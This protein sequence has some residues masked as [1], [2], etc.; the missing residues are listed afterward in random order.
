[1]SKLASLMIAASLALTASAAASAA[2]GDITLRVER[3]GIMTS[4]GGEFASAQSGKMLVEGE[5]LMV[6]E[7]SAA[8]VFY[9]NNCTR[10]YNAP[11]VY[12]IE[13]DCK[14]GAVVAR[15]TDWAGAGMVAAG[16]VVGAALL[17][18]MDK[19]PGQYPAPP[20]P[21]APLPISR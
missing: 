6:T 12:V 13:R 2:D 7:G 14:R 19:A 18:N 5:R 17:E 16:V 4:Q 9:S 10:E 21:P 15:N 8:T 20:V 1:M 11:G 3:G